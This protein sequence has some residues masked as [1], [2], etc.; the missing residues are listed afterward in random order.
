MKT[1]RS[2]QV[3]DEV[4]STYADAALDWNPIHFDDQFAQLRGLDSRIAHGMIS[5]S[6]ISALMTDLRGEDWLQHGELTLKFIKPC[7]PNQRVS[8][9]AAETEEP[10]VYKVTATD[11]SGAALIAGTASIEP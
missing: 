10:G 2:L 8:A 3:T 11:E 7:A 1:T 4:I 5:G 9:S 6:L